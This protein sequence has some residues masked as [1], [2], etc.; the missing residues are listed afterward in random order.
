MTLSTL[1]PLEGNGGYVVGSEGLYRADTL[2]TTPVLISGTQAAPTPIAA[3]FPATAAGGISGG[4][5]VTLSAPL[6]TY[7]SG[8][9]I[10]AAGNRVVEAAD[11]GAILFGGGGTITLTRIPSGIAL[12]PNG[13]VPYQVSLRAWNSANASSLVRV[14][15]ASS[16]PMGNAGSGSVALQLP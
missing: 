12:A 1:S 16:V 15:A 14:A 10:I 7:D 9:V 3:P 13:G 4:V 8:L 2:A 5:R 6:G 11:V